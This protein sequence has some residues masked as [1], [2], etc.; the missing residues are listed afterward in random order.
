MR[1]FTMKLRAI[2]NLCTVKPASAHLRTNSIKW[3]STMSIIWNKLSRPCADEKTRKS[4]LWQAA[5]FVLSLA[6]VWTQAERIEGSE[7]TG[8]RVTGPIFMLFERGMFVFALAIFLT[9][10]YR[11]IAALVGIVACLLCF[12]FYLYFLAPGPFR[13]V[14]RGI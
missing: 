7:F 5:S 10:V 9:F 1:P 6:L 11:R 14:F 13:S 12:P 8:G 3:Q 2:A 4:E